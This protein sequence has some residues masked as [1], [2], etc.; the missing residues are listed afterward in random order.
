MNTGATSAFQRIEGKARMRRDHPLRANQ[1]IVN[2]ALSALER[3]V[4]DLIGS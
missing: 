4:V 3:E 1:V 2:E